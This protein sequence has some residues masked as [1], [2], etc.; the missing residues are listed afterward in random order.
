MNKTMQAL[1]TKGGAVAVGVV[2]ILIIGYIVKKQA[3][4]AIPEAAKAVGQAVNPINDENIF[5]TGVNAIGGYI[6]GEDNWKLGA[7]IYDW[8]H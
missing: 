1:N 3:E 2:G 5:Y 8:T 7:K 6:S 4:E